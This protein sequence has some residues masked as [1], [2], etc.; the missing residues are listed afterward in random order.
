MRAFEKIVK[1]IE[2]EELKPPSLHELANDLQDATVDELKRVVHTGTYNAELIAFR[3]GWRKWTWKEN[4]GDELIDPYGFLGPTN[5]AIHDNHVD[6]VEIRNPNKLTATGTG[7]L[8]NDNG[9]RLRGCWDNGRVLP[10]REL[11]YP[12]YR[13]LEHCAV[14][15]GAKFLWLMSSAKLSPHYFDYGFKRASLFQVRNTKGARQNEDAT[16]FFRKDL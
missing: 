11:R 5:I 8:T 3:A 2:G 4:V 16:A 12:I 10:D 14:A 7:Y 9:Y 15:A 1:I 13:M 6:I